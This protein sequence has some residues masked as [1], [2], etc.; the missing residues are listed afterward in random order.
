MPTVQVRQLVESLISYR[1]KDAGLFGGGDSPF[2][3]GT[4]TVWKD[5]LRAAM[6]LLALIH[7]TTTNA[8]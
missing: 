8:T 7:W 2:C 6:Q 3:N 1:L 4:L 5:Q